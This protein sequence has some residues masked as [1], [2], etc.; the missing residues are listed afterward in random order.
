MSPSGPW[1]PTRLLDC[2]RRPQ[3]PTLVASLPWWQPAPQRAP[4]TLVVIPELPHSKHP[5]GFSI[6]WPNFLALA[7]GRTV[8]R[9]KVALSIPSFIPKFNSVYE[10]RPEPL[11]NKKQGCGPHPEPSAKAPKAGRASISMVYLLQNLHRSG[12][13]RFSIRFRKAGSM[14]FGR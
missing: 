12:F 13:S 14:L 6:F 9:Q 10:C 3:R 7:S 11:Q 2:S 5:G 8:S 4:K 1:S